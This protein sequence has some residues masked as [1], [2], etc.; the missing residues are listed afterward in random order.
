MIEINKPGSRLNSKSS[1]KTKSGKTKKTGKTSF[2]QELESTITHEY[3]GSIDALMNDLKDQEKRF[4]DMQS[5]YELEKYKA[6]IKKILKSILEEGYETGTL[7]RRRRDRADFT[8]MKTIDD[9][10]FELSQAITRGNKA[11][12]FFKTIEEIRGLVF[13]LVY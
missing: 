10:L 5:L 11:F 8:V 3:T 1:V 6:L 9:K 2:S 12:S 13:D 7:R 4:L